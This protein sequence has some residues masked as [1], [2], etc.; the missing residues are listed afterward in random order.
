MLRRAPRRRHG[1]AA[2]RAATHP[3][4]RNSENCKRKVPLAMLPSA[5]ACEESRHQ[6]PYPCGTL[7]HIWPQVFC[8]PCRTLPKHMD[9]RFPWTETARNP[10]LQDPWVTLG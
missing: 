8:Q 10:D 5:A 6:S 3:N 2:R 4:E 9:P 7:E 1:C